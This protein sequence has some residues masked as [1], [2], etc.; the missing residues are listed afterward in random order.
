VDAEGPRIYYLHPLLAGPLAMWDVHFARIAAMGFS[1][2]LIAPPFQPAAHGSLML[3]STHDALHDSLC[4]AG[5][6]DDGLRDIARR[7]RANGLALWLDVVPE[8]VANRSA[9]TVSPDSPFRLPDTTLDPNRF[10]PD[11]DAAHA[12]LTLDGM[13]S[14][15]AF[16]RQRLVHWAGLGVAGFRLTGLVDIPAALVTAMAGALAG[17]GARLVGWM[18]G[19]PLARLPGFVGLGLDYVFSSFPWWDG[20][21]SWF[22]REYSALRQISPV[23]H[24]AEAPFGP[25]LGAAVRK[26]RISLACL[27]GTGWMLPMGAEFGATARMNAMGDTG[28]DFAALLALPREDLTELVAALNKRRRALLPLSGHAAPRMLTGGGQDVLA[29]LRTE[30]AD[31]RLPGAGALVAIGMAQAGGRLAGADMCAG[32]GGYFA[33]PPALLL[34]RRLACGEVMTEPLA[35]FAPEGAGADLTEG[36]MAAAQMPRIAIEDV[37]PSVPGGSFP[38]RFCLGEQV[39]VAADLIC[40]G[41][42]MLSAALRVTAPDGS[43]ALLPM[44]PIGNDRWQAALPLLRLGIYRCT[45]E[46]WKDVFGTYRE[47]L[48]KKVTA[49]LTVALEIEE[50]RIL[51]RE[52]LARSGDQGDVLRTKLARAE[53]PDARDCVAA[54]MDEETALCMRQVDERSFLSVLDAPLLIE[55]ERTA[56]RFASWYEVF[57]RSLSDDTTRHGTFEDVIRHLPRIAAMGF[58]VLYFPPIHPIGH[59][60]RKGRNNSLTAEEGDPGSPYGIADHT[61]LHPELGGFD[62]FAR[63]RDAALRH[64]LELALD[65]A[66]QCSPDHRWLTEHKGWF[67]WRPDGSIRYAENPPKKYQDIVNVDFYASDAIPSL[68]RELCQVVLFWCDQG[69]RIFRVDNPHTKPLPFWQWMI[70]QVRARHPDTL[71]L[72][73][74]FTRPKVMNRLAKIGFSQSYTYFTWRNTKAEFIEYMSELTGA[75]A[76]Y[77]RPNFFVNTPDINPVFLHESGR[78]GHLIRAALAATLAG[79]WGVY[80]GFELC[81]ATPLPGREEYF[82]SEKYQLRA[83][84]WNRSGNIVAEIAQL[85]LIR[86]TNPCLQTHLG[87]TFL[88][89]WNDQILYFEKATAD[90]GNVVLVAISLDPL[91]PQ[92]ADIELPLWRWS[93]PDGATLIAEDLV[94]GAGFTWTGKIQRLHLDPKYL[95]YAI[96]RVRPA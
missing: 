55:C 59:T 88:N 72:A 2:V 75:P 73:E 78:P 70:G 46:A 30:T 40:D 34:D 82:D 85:N 49:G 27:L 12:V 95:P 64:G 29:F 68:W 22:W 18:P 23:L 58:D 56:A 74:A 42:D 96:Y 31:P 50:G 48:R 37:G 9:L 93:L 43:E 4:W 79:L 54:L 17:T 6:A 94:T 1:H 15:A 57:P 84:D 28:E 77:F 62:D 11:G 71:F 91:A 83:W 90:R 5:N 20:E 44:Q 7:A 26:Y 38:A 66:I 67:D 92:E 16:W 87:L 24:S 39:T 61:A 14:L 41:H 10:D 65:F 36:A 86:R 45:V 52:A 89:A 53:A 47:E 63:L 80:S 33:V 21:A 69:V 35:W 60:N 81:E 13:P 32:L 76:A 8:R 25:R 51:L 3:S 19:V